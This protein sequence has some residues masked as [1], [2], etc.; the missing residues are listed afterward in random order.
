[1]NDNIIIFVKKPC[2][3]AIIKVELNDKIYLRDPESTDLGRK[4]ISQSIQ[5][6]DQ[7]GFEQFTFKKLAVAIDST[8]A[9]IYRYFENKHKLLIYLISWYWAWLDY[10]IGFHT[11]N[12][13][14]PREKL[15]IIIRLISETHGE[16]GYASSIDQATLF[17][18]VVSEASK[19]YLTKE[20]DADNKVGLFRD[21]KSLCHKIALL[22][23]EINPSH[24][25]PHAMVSTLFEVARK[26]VFFAQH[27]PSLTE[28]KDKDYNSLAIF[29]EHLVFSSIAG[30]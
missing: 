7:L 15:R 20:V 3:S 26:Q 5:L 2:M 14:D 19:A 27:L 6:I 21:Y 30:V 11:N 13:F 9:S 22:V 28:V 25:F 24:P 10:Q 1:M 17:R 29:L 12:I 8:E 18:I 16:P 23:L 4:I